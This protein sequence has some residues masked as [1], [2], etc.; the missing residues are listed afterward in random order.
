MYYLVI[1]QAKPTDAG[2][3]VVV[4]RNAVGEAQ[5][6]A[7]LDIFLAQDFRRH[8]LKSTPRGN[9]LVQICKMMR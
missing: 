3:V 4:A 8:Q 1:P 6:Q 9:L 5:A 7:S 2:E